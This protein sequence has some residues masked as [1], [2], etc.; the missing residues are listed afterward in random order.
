VVVVGE[1]RRYWRKQFVVFTVV[2]SWAT[3]GLCI[4][5]NCDMVRWSAACHDREEQ[6][7][8]NEGRATTSSVTG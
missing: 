3:N 1:G 8:G 6:R 2:S 4:V 5:I 7:Y